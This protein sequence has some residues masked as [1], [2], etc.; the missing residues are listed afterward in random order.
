M[1]FV[2]VSVSIPVQ[3]I[4]SLHTYCIEVRYDLLKSIILKGLC[5]CG[6]D[7]ILKW[8]DWWISL[9]K[10][11]RKW[12]VCVFVCF[13]VYIHFLGYVCLLGYT[14]IFKIRIF[15]VYIYVFGVYMFFKIYV[16]MFLDCM[17]GWCGYACIVY[18]YVYTKTTCT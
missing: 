10:T 18:E 5:V 8:I 12:C 15:L 16:Y 4:E 6:L 11:L 3:S 17:Y 9:M 2:S 1:I 13:L 14:C 7:G